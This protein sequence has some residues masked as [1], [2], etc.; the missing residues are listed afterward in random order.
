[1]LVF[2]EV[3]RF[4]RFN[5]EAAKQGEGKTFMAI[6]NYGKTSAQSFYVLY[7]R[8]SQEILSSHII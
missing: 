2:K 4:L 1:M 3:E 8:V 7:N 5:T 6:K